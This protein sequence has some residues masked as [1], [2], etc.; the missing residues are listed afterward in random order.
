MTTDEIRSLVAATRAVTKAE[1][2]RDEARKALGRVRHLRDT[3]QAH[4]SDGR[5]PS[6]HHEPE[7]SCDH[8]EGYHHALSDLSVALEGKP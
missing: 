7:T 3:W 2:E 8:G 6:C 1:R 5:C 4:L